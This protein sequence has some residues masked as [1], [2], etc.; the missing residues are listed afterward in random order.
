[1]RSFLTGG[2][3]LRGV[4]G[5]DFFKTTENCTSQISEKWEKILKWVQKNAPGVLLPWG[6]SKLR[7]ESNGMPP[8]V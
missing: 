5:I 3:G 7:C 8:G 6:G 2:I 1:M 4:P